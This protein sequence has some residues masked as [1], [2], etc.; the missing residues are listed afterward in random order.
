MQSL[1]ASVGTSK[2]R[3]RVEIKELTRRVRGLLRREE[4]LL[5]IVAEQQGEIEAL[6][7][8]NGVLRA[9]ELFVIGVLSGMDGQ[10]RQAVLVAMERTAAREQLLPGVAGNV[11]H[12]LE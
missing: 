8:R 6:T 3:L 10:G 11:R 4:D 1:K 7:E 9:V 5:G 12:E 2:R